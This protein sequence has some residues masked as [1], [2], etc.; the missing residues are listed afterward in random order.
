M[1]PNQ[2]PMHPGGTIAPQT[3]A[4]MPLASDA[5]RKEL[6]DLI[7]QIK[8][9][10]SEAKTAQF[11]ADTTGEQA[12]QNAL[13]GVF[14]ALQNAGVDLTD[15][16]SVNEFLTKLRQNNPELAQIF[17]ESLSQLLGD[18]VPQDGSM[19]GQTEQPMNNETIPENLRGPSAPQQGQEPIA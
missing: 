18:D 2:Q 10:M 16:N 11:A 3:A 15:P 4:G 13:Q 12:R 1:D 5:Q 7:E 8:S 17:E 9:K 6:M 14:T 19:L